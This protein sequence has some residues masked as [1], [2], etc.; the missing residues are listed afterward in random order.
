MCTSF[1]SCQYGDI[2][3]A[4]VG[5]CK[6]V[7]YHAASPLELLRPLVLMMGKFWTQMLLY[8]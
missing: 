2:V 6:G 8:K 3:M 5:Q 4:I 1:A 7:V